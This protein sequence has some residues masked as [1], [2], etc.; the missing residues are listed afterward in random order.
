[1]IHTSV[2]SFTMFAATTVLCNSIKDCLKLGISQNS[3]IGN[4]NIHQGKSREFCLLEMLGTLYNVFAF[5]SQNTE[6]LSNTSTAS[7]RRIQS[8]PT[9]TST[10]TK[11]DGPVDPTAT[12]TDVKPVVLPNG[13]V[14]KLVTSQYLNGHKNG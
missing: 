6:E 13:Q 12:I 9:A 7:F 1:M 11:V 5:F 4:L 3:F 2:F 14:G 8:E 10:P